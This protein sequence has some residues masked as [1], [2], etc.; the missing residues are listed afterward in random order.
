MQKGCDKCDHT[1]FAYGNIPCV[2]T[3]SKVHK[4]IPKQIEKMISVQPMQDGPHSYPNG[5]PP[6]PF[7]YPNSKPSEAAEI[8]TQVKD[9]DDDLRISY[10]K[11]ES[12]AIGDLIFYQNKILGTCVE[13][14]WDNCI[15]V[16]TPNYELWN[17]KL[18]YERVRINHVDI[19]YFITKR[20]KP[21]WRHEMDY[22]QA[23]DLLYLDKDGGIT[24]QKGTLFGICQ[25]DNKDGT[26]NVVY[27]GAILK[28]W[29]AKL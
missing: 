12:P 2:C 9:N 4:D 13:I 3:E 1:G 22:I 24:T 20:P 16:E 6:G 7:F 17:Q 27:D 15:I 25:Q 14:P 28:L 5:Y 10:I 18:S 11:D 26:V 21:K 23:G 29:K 8:D 19:S